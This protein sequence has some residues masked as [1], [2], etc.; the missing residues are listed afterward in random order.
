MT[1]FGKSGI[2]C[3]KKLKDK[4]RGCSG[5]RV[6]SALEILQKMY[7]L[8]GD[9]T[10]KRILCAILAVLMLCSVGV[11]MVSCSTYDMEKMQEKCEKLKEKGEI[12]EYKYDEEEKELIAISKDGYIFI[13]KEYDGITDATDAVED[14]LEQKGALYRM[15][16]GSGANGYVMYKASGNVAI[17]YTNKD[18]SKK[19]A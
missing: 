17:G 13:A 10:V 2:I 12:V 9:L 14:A 16:V 7:F 6:A 5:V 8:K 19:I 4:V 18:F 15:M 3:L 1:I 11:A